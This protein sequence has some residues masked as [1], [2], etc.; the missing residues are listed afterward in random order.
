MDGENKKAQVETHAL[1]FEI[2]IQPA[3]TISLFAMTLWTVLCSSK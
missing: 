2:L 1:L 3:S